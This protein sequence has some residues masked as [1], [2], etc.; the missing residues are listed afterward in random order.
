[1]KEHLKNHSP[2]R[3]ALKKTKNFSEEFPRGSMPPLPNPILPIHKYIFLYQREWL[4]VF[5]VNSIPTND[6]PFSGLIFPESFTN[7]TCTFLWTKFEESCRVE[8]GYDKE[9]RGSNETAKMTNVSRRRHPSMFC[10]GELDCWTNEAN[11]A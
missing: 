10:G 11:L 6:D 4:D 9:E 2:V 8:R 7:L 3:L 5:G 1:M